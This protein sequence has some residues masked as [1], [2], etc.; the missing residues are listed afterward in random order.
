MLPCFTLSA[1]LLNPLP[2]NKIVDVTKLK[3]FADNKL[4]VDKMTFS[5]FDE[6]K[7]LLEI[8]KMLVT[9]IFSLSHSVFQSPLLKGS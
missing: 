3:A 7:T 2:N 4:N 5:L 1:L 8:E 6:K 9:S